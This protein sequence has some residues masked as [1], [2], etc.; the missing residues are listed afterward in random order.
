[1]RQEKMTAPHGAVVFLPHTQMNTDP[2]ERILGHHAEVL[3]LYCITY[4]SAQLKS[5]RTLYLGLYE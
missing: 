1:M 4:P 5:L 3:L 2:I